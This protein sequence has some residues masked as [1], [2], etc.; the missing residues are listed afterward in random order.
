MIRRFPGGFGAVV[1]AEA[2]S[3]DAGMIETRA[4]ERI[5]IMT[6]LAFVA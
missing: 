5:G 2:G 6:V 3:G 4:S 1:A